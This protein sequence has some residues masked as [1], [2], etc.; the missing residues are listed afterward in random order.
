MEKMRWI[1]LASAGSVKRFVQLYR[2]KNCP[3]FAAK[4]HGII[5][6]IAFRGAHISRAISKVR[7]S[8]A[9]GEISGIAKDKPA[10]TQKTMCLF[11]TGLFSY[12]ILIK[13]FLRANHSD[14]EK[15]TALV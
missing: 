9:V 1:K 5:S 2:K 8:V 7:K 12:I 4:L 14:I 6:I 13:H 3:T 11:K 15:E 10:Y